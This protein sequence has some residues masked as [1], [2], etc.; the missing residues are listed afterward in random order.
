MTKDKDSSFEREAQWKEGFH[1]SSKGSRTPLKE[2]P[3]TYLKNI[4]AKY[5]N[6]HDVA[7]IEKEIA[8][9]PEEE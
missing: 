9:R 3:T 6:D 8:S 5:S 1:V 7:D 4:A 2:L